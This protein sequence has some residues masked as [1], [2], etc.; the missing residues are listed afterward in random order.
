M[1]TTDGRI[2]FVFLHGSG[3]NGRELAQY[4]GAIPMGGAAYNFDS[5]HDVCLARNIQ[6][7]TPTADEIPYSP[8]MQMPLTV[9]YDRSA[10]YL[11]E[12]LEDGE[13]KEG[14]ERSLSIILKMINAMEADFHHIFLGGFSMGGGLALHALSKASQLSPKVRGIFTFGSYLVN[15]SAVLNKS[16]NA[17]QM[18]ERAMK[19]EELKQSRNAAQAQT[20]AAINPK[21]KT[22]GGG[23]SEE[24]GAAYYISQSAESKALNEKMN[25]KNA[26]L[27][28]T[29]DG[30]VIDPD[31]KDAHTPLV[32]IPVLM[33]HGEEDALISQEW[34]KATATN[35]LL[36][37][38]DV[39]YE[40]FKGLDHEIGEEQLEECLTWLLDV[41]AVV[42][43][44]ELE[45]AAAMVAE[46][47]NNN[48][49]GPQGSGSAGTI[50]GRVDDKTFDE[51]R[52]RA[53]GKIHVS[54]DKVASAMKSRTEGVI[55]SGGAS[56][57]GSGSG[58]GSSSTRS[59]QP[60]SVTLSP[61]DS[62]VT[63]LHFPANESV[64]DIL[65]ARPV[66]ACGGMFEMKKEKLEGVSGV[67]TEIL[68]AQDVELLANEIG[69]RLRKRIESEGASLN[70][71]P[72]A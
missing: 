58:S 22:P 3:G 33:M 35:L 48:M 65:V 17:M 51:E 66:L 20:K 50:A 21:K 57:G 28:Y 63:I 32:D 16:T 44:E 53:L 62:N 31:D 69:T 56:V 14:I 52:E 71:C 7:F 70:A 6:I 40:T 36:R 1:D 30:K 55:R 15:G 4:F 12:G 59:A 24:T 10:N 19:E 25:R 11:E 29:S 46:N 13:D 45:K 72:M 47:A 27:E 34:G 23:K 41:A 39:R 61:K 38:V 64:V 68:F 18:E 67:Y 26:A 54:A 8:A 42:E 2:A 49:H 60:Y 9:W 43:D 5:F 37:G